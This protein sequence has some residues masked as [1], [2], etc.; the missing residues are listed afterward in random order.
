MKKSL[1][2]VL[3]ALTIAAVV[4]AQATAQLHGVVQDVS[5]AA[6]PNAT[7]TVR[8]TDT[9]PERKRLSRVSSCRLTA[10]PPSRFRLESAG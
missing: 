4:W 7:I 1:I 5:G 8:Q 6:V 9:G 2:L 10:T 3:S